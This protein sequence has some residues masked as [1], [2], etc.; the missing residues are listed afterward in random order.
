MEWLLYLL[1][2]IIMLFYMKKIFFKKKKSNYWDDEPGELIFFHMEVQK[3]QKQNK[4]PL[5][6]LEKHQGRPE[7]Q[8]VI[9]FQKQ[10]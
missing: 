6:S 1:L 7:S 9:P 3:L 10:I 2:P 4:K 8:K 5:D